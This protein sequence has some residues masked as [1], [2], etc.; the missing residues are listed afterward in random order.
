MYVVTY[1]SEDVIPRENGA[2]RGEQSKEERA[3]WG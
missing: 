3:I 2:Y 1:I